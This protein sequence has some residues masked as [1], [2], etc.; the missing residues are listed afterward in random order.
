MQ[1]WV[2]LKRSRGE[3][4]LIGGQMSEFAELHRSLILNS[5]DPNRDRVDRYRCGA[6]FPVI[7]NFPWMAPRDL[8][9]HLIT[10]Y[11][12]VL[13]TTVDNIEHIESESLFGI[14]VVKAFLGVFAYPRKKVQS[15]IFS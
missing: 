14:A 2:L 13:T 4:E 3:R 12:R 10:V 1:G 8:E 9:E 15:R 6:A 5:T 7:F 11:E